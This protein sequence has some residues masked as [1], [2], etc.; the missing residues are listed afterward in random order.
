MPSGLTGDHAAVEP[1]TSSRSVPPRAPPAKLVS[2][3]CLPGSGRASPPPR[4]LRTRTMAEN[5]RGTSSVV[6]FPR[7][8]PVRPSPVSRPTP[9]ALPLSLTHGPALTAPYP[10]VSFPHS[11]AVWAR[12][13]VAPRAR[14]RLKSPSPAQLYENPFS[15]SFSLFSFSHLHI[16]LYVDILCTKNSPKNL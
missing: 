3:S 2:S 7:P 4:P 8:R 14:A 13:H 5:R 1:A 6:G 12:S 16:Y 15:F 9:S 10:P 11:W